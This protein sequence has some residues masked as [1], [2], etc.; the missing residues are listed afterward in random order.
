MTSG[1]GAHQKGPLV[2][3]NQ[4]DIHSLKEVIY[5]THYREANPGLL[6][7]ALA[8]SSMT[9]VSNMIQ[10]IFLYLGNLYIFEG[11]LLHR[12]SEVV[13]MH[14]FLTNLL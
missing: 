5:F 7:F 12:M 3:I 13:Q 9:G 1:C 4:S 8:E 2:V 10:Y 11:T 14:P 6:S